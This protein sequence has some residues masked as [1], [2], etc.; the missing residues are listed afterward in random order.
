MPILALL[1]SSCGQKEN[2]YEL[3]VVGGTPSGVAAAVAAARSGVRVALISGNRHI[4]GMLVSA[5]GDV[6]SGAPKYI[7]G[8][9]REVFEGIARH[10]E[11]T[12][13]PESEQFRDCHN[14]LRFE[15]HVAG[16]VFDSL[17]AAEPNIT[18]YRGYTFIDSW[19]RSSRID[20]M[21]ARDFSDC[22]EIRIAGKFFIDATYTGDLF[23]SAG[24]PYRT[25]RESREV[26]GEELA[27]NIYQNPQT[28]LPYPI[29][30]GEGDSLIQAYTFRLCI[31]DSAEN[32]VPFPEPQSYDPERYRGLYGWM[33]DW[34]GELNHKSFMEFTKLPNR[35][36]D[37]NN[38][39]YCRVSTDLIGG[40]NGYPEAEPC[41]RP[42]IDREHLEHILGLWKFLRE[43]PG[44]PDS[45]RKSFARYGLAKDE[46]NSERI[47][48]GLPR[49]KR[50]N[51]NKTL[52]CNEDSPRL[53]AGSLQ[54][55]DN[56]NLP[57]QLYVREGRRLA[58]IDCFTGL[59]ATTDTLKS[60]AIAMGSY[61]LSSHATGG[62]K[63][64][65]PRAEGFFIFSARPCQIPYRIMVPSWSRN[66]LISLCVSASHV[67]YGSLRAEPVSME[68]GQAA[69]EAAALALEFN[70][71]SSEVPV[72]ILQNKLR[73]KGAIL[74]HAEARSWAGGDSIE[75]QREINGKRRGYR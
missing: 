37:Q 15:P 62:F 35:K 75:T 18:V 14:G 45:L 65:Y 30:S 5:L 49:G 60:D 51:K 61:P 7:G 29:S 34:D 64:G 12:Y 74:S 10:Y 1:L 53:A 9:A 73:E 20:S 70:V 23:A 54:F 19:G 39:G 24:D 69:G 31:T 11:S 32:S 26:F 59:D 55:T 22:G 3:V 44:I 13:G 72:Q 41:D 8:I 36:Y 68:L 66:L 2:H 6:D 57:F 28:G 40:S 71:E 33:E 46:L 42:L 58:A 25:G 27:G 48:R 43:D 67:A 38:S 63:D 50:A 56:A 52:P 21:L 16:M 4:G 17:V 47:P